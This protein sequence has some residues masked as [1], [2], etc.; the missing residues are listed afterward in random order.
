LL[1]HMETDISV[2]TLALRREMAAQPRL[3]KIGN[4]SKMLDSMHPFEETRISLRPD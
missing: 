4:R 3:N 2:E 1:V